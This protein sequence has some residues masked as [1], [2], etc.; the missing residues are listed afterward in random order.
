MFHVSIQRAGIAPA[1]IT[2]SGTMPGLEPSGAGALPVSP[3]AAFRA[4]GRTELLFYRCQKTSARIKRVDAKY[5][6]RLGSRSAADWVWHD[7]RSSCLTNRS[8]SETGIRLW[9]R[10]GNTRILRRLIKRSNEAYEMPIWVAA[11]AAETVK[12]ACGKSGSFEAWT[13]SIFT[14]FPLPAQ[15]IHATALDRQQ[16]CRLSVAGT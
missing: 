3:A 9:R 4:L 5:L 15:R 8:T 14:S 16:R 6:G 12:Q 2:S 11:S 7:Q 10:C 1:Q 13:F